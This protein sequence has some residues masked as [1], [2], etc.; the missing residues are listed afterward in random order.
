MGVWQDQLE[1]SLSKFL[2]TILMRYARCVCVCDNHDIKSI[3][4]FV[5]NA[6]QQGSDEVLRGAEWLADVVLQPSRL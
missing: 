4:I 5:V 1:A 6:V 3:P 2:G